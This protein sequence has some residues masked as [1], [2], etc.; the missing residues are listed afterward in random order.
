MRA[1]GRWDVLA[2]NQ[3]L[4]LLNLGLQFNLSLRLLLSLLRLDSVG[5]I[6]SSFDLDALL[7]ICQALLIE[8]TEDLPELDHLV[9]LKLDALEKGYLVAHVFLLDLRDFD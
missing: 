5:F 7:L 9:K 4:L 2:D 6:L 1:E 3:V 8:P